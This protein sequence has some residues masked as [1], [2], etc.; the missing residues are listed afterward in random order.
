MWLY[1]RIEAP[2]HPPSASWLPNY[3]NSQNQYVQG[4]NGVAYDPGGNGNLLN[5][6]FNSYTWDVYGDMA[7]AN[8]VTAT[9]DA[10]GRMVELANGP[11]RALAQLVYSP[12]DGSVLA[13][14]SAQGL[15]QAFAQLPGG[16][17][18]LYVSSSNV[19]YYSHPDWLGS[20]RLLSTP[21]RGPIPT[22]AYAPFGEGYAGGLAGYVTF[23]SGGYAFTVNPGENQGSGLDDF[24]FRRYSPGQSRW[25]SP[26]PAGLASVDPTNPQTW[27]RYAYVANNPLS[28]VDPSGLLLAGPGGCNLI[29]GCGAPGFDG[30]GGGTDYQIDGISVSSSV[31]GGF[32]G[33]LG[34]PGG[35]GDLAMLSFQVQTG[36]SVIGV[37]AN[38]TITVG[39]CGNLP[40]C[41]TQE[42]PVYDTIFPFAFLAG[43]FGPGGS[44]SPATIGN[45]QSAGLGFAGFNMQK[46][47]AANYND[48]TGAFH[49][50]SFG[51][52]VQLGSLTA[53]TPLNSN[54][55]D[56]WYET[57]SLGSV[58]AA[59]LG[60][61]K[62]GSAMVG[63]AVESAIGVVAS[64]FLLTATGIDTNVSA[65]CAGSAVLA[66]APPGN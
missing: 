27:N 41:Q 24:M 61:M 51:K 3:N 49:Q 6:S 12:A 39:G 14:T 4:W 40:G 20:T 56:N 44:R 23:T 9:Y 36:T 52:L 42:F 32:L 58:K 35:L 33:S 45:W 15:V 62:A 8:G 66:S 7:S 34:F 46:A 10:F 31:F 22:M 53:L 19:Y 64:P 28:F 63:E 48:C 47:V 54:Y 11:Q 18:A 30:G 38:G 65:A 25:I 26:D 2:G 21:S 5:D 37:D 17:Y 50:T 1:Q 13:E 60:G 43:L 16:G 29:D 55:A 57:L 59:F